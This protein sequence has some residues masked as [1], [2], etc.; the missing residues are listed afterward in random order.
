VKDRSIL[1]F[2]SVGVIGGAETNFINIA[3]EL[4]ERGCKI[5]VAVVKN[6][7]P[8]LTLIKPYV[9]GVIVL[10]FTKPFNLVKLIRLYKAFLIKNNIHTVL[11]FGLKIEIFS[12]I[13][14]KCL[15]AK[16]IISNIRSTDDWRKWYHTL[17]DRLTQ[18]NVD[19][20]ISNSKAGKEA[21][22]E[23]EKII[24]DKCLVIY[25]YIE[26]DIDPLKD[27]FFK[28]KINIGILSNIKED[29]GFEDLIK[30]SKR[31][32]EEGIKFK[33][34]IAGKD[35]MNGY[36]QRMV[37]SKGLQ[38]YFEFLGYI[39]DKK[40]FFNDIDLFLLPTY[41]EG[42][43]TSILEAMKYGV[44]V[45]STNVGGIPELII[46]N[47]NGYLTTP[48]NIEGFFNGIELLIHNKKIYNNYRINAHQMLRDKFVKSKIIKEWLR[49]LSS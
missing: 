4:S 33:F 1:F 18:Y 17:M 5:Y 30:L 46:H 7:G 45:I 41:I 21:F 32:K 22:V 31:L 38:D 16:Y 44:P 34:I 20:W 39:E 19:L 23:R 29:K 47:Y 48:G 2:F 25:N 15:G 3:K 28:D 10:D 49:I 40:G 6:N 35:L 42:L 9:A 8:L 27:L 24:R 11:N 12:R 37:F 13:F 26:D 36:F 14:S 43:P